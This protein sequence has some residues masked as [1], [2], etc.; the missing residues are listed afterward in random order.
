ME[1][2][3]KIA[4]VNVF[5]TSPASFGDWYALRKVYIPLHLDCK[6]LYLLTYLRKAAIGTTGDRKTITVLWASSV[7]YYPSGI[8]F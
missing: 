3:N 6:I 2:N 4:Y 8:K 5:L 7:G 1:A